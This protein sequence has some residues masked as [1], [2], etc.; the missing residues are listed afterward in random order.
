M[1]VPNPLPGVGP[2]CSD[3][4]D[5]DGDGFVDFAPMQLRGQPYPGQPGKIWG[6]PDCTNELDISESP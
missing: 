6:D 4:L 5:N 1:P 2:Q 3:G